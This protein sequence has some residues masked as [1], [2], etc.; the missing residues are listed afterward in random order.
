[1]IGLNAKAYRN[2]GSRE[3][4]TLSEMTLISD[5]SVN[6]AWDEADASARESRIKQSVKTLLMLDITGK[7]KKKPGDANYEALMDAMLSDGVLELF[8][9]DGDKDTVGVR[10]WRADFQVFSTNEDQ[11]MTNVLFEEFSL[12]PSITS[13]APRAVKVAAGPTLTYSI[14][15]T[16]GGT[17]A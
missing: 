13:Y 12:K 15:G 14:P 16:S 5:L 7:M 11:S 10:G 6:P 1:M 4:P 17:F 2:T 9:L 8:I 3:S